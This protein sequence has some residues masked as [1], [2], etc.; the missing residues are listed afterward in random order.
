MAVVVSLLLYA[1]SGLLLLKMLYDK[2]LGRHDLITLRNVALLGLIVF[3]LTSATI[4]LLTGE[5][6]QYLLA[7]PAQSGLTLLGMSLVFIVVFLWAYRKGFLVARLAQRTPTARAYPTGGTLWVIAVV[8]T[9]LAVLLRFFV[10]IPVVGAAANY[11]GVS[12]AAIACGICG[13]LWAPRLFNPAVA[14]AA[15]IIVLLNTANVISGT[16]GR[17]TLVA[18]GGCLVW[19]MYYSHWRYLPVREMLVRVVAI[20]AIPVAVLALF[21]SVRSS[22][23]HERSAGQH[24]Q[25]IRYGG[26]LKTGLLLL[27]D[28]Q[29]TGLKTMWIIENVP[30][31]HPY[32]HMLTVKY[33]FLLPIPRMWWP[34]KP[35]PL[36]TKIAEMARLTGVDRSRLK[37]GPG[38]LGHARAEG[39][40]YTLLLYPLLG[41]LLL[42]YFDELVQRNPANPLVVLPVGSALGQVVG[43]AR[44][45]TSVFAMGFVIGVLG[46]YASMILLAKALELVGWGRLEEQPPEDEEAGDAPDEEQHEPAGGSPRPADAA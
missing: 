20:T 45:E 37:V 30:S 5:H 3:Q 44:G 34:E 22:K 15:G 4:P 43:L 9:V 12:F 2:Y 14:V 23:E 29:Q 7:R 25:A 39:G 11:V 41:A 10:F 6:G 46:A 35:L 26:N 24:V 38:I 27:L 33:F 13:W 31:S 1:L 42:R 36:S 18:I 19:G 8:L 17:R 21:T 40:W 32:Q 16:F 28:G